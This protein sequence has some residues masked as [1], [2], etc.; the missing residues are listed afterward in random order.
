MGLVRAKNTKPEMA[1]RRLVHA[2]GYRYRLHGRSLPGRPDMVFA[3]RRKVI[4]VHGCF[5][6]RH[7]KCAKATTPRANA[8]F[9]LAKFR[10]NRRRDRRI[11]RRLTEAG[12]GVIIV[13]ECELREPAKLKSRLIREF[14][15]YG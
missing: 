5:W 8:A 9:W 7:T 4:F 1:V 11:E 12:W 14:G 3:S 13:W 2:L 6:H 15:K 10:A